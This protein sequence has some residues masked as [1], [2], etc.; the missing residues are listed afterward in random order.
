VLNKFIRKK[1][2]SY[3]GAGLGTESIFLYSLPLFVT[4]YRFWLV[5]V[6]DLGSTRNDVKYNNLV[7]YIY[8]AYLTYYNPVETV[9]NNKRYAA[10][11]RT[12]NLW[13]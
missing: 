4:C 5:T 12:F 7:L 9:V 8:D 2:F 3:Q 13:E 1:S 10:L 6:H 11:A